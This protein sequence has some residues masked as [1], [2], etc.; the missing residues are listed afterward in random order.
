MA[1]IFGAVAS[2]AG[3]VS[4]S[5]QLIE[6]TQKLKS[7]YNASREAPDTLADLCEELQIL[8]MNLRLLES[9]R[10][11]N[12]LGDELLEICVSKCARMI[13]KIQ[14]S[15]DKMGSLMNRSRLA[16]RLYTAFKEP[17]IKQLL[18]EM[19]R[20]KGSLLTACLSYYQ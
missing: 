20:A 16:G 6:S 18:E 9:H 19:E 11:N 4:L 3:L 15:V 7:F 13:A 2:G 1:E 17:E 8:S 14:T 12:I 10:Q 5:M